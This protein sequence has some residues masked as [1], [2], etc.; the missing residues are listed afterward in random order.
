[1]ILL[2][3][4]NKI[5][6]AWKEKLHDEALKAEEEKEDGSKEYGS[7][8]CNWARKYDATVN[9]VGRLLSYIRDTNVCTHSSLLCITV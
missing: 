5:A 1:M 4:K 9:E 8:T 2:G 7:C 3:R 6:Q